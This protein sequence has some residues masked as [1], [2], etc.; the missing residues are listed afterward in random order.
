M[1]ASDR[2][3]SPVPARNRLEP[4]GQ[5]PPMPFF[6]CWCGPM[7]AAVRDLQHMPRPQNQPKWSLP[8]S[9]RYMMGRMWSVTPPALPNSWAASQPFSPNPPNLP[10]PPTLPYPSSQQCPPT[11]PCS[12]TPPPSISPS[13]ARPTSTPQSRPPSN[14]DKNEATRVYGFVLNDHW[15]SDR[16]HYESIRH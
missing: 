8:S 1:A 6:P 14:S 9:G 13:Q 15:R 16:D 2:S 4:H 12:P 11:Q 10:L 7:G 3:R 5:R